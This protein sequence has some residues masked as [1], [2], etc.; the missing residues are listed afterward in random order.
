L[1]LLYCSSTLEEIRETTTEK[2]IM[3]LESELS[4]FTGTEKY[5]RFSILFRSLVLTDGAKYLAEKAE[6]YWLMDI[7]GSILPLIS[8]KSGGFCGA[9]IA[10][11]KGTSGAVFTADD[12]N[13]NVFYTQKI[14]YTDF[15]LDEY[16]LYVCDNGN[17]WVILLPS[18]Y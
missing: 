12:G 15:P 10:K 2:K 7:I 11:I 6:C 14:P 4:Q 16:K 8:I 1:T 3:H 17:V 5:H 18:E 13:G 9:T